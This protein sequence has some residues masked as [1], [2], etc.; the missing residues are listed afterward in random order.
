MISREELNQF[1]KIFTC[2]ICFCKIRS[3]RDEHFSLEV[4]LPLIVNIRF[5]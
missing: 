2:I 4:F 3:A 5:L 1:Q